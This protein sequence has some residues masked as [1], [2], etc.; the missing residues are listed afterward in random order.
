M[1]FNRVERVKEEMKRELSAII[2]ELKDPRISQMTSV[3]AADVTK[4]LKYAKVYVSSFMQDKS[5]EKGVKGLQS[6][7]GYIQSTIGKKLTIRQFPKL[8]FIAD[9]SIKD[10]FEMVQKL[11][12]IEKEDAE[13]ARILAESGYVSSSDAE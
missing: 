11:N 5:V 8:T 3:V 6:A 12:E 2:R 7:A 4:D 10:G 13:K 1:A 9:S